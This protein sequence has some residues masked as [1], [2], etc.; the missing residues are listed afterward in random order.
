LVRGYGAETALAE[1]APVRSYGL[2]YSFNGAYLAGLVE[3]V[4]IALVVKFIN[5]VE[6]F[7]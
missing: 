2:F 3:R 7:G 6:F 4:G 1:T 5:F